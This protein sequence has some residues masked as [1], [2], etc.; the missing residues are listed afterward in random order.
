[1]NL[2]LRK[3]KKIFGI[4]ARWAYLCTPFRGENKVWIDLTDC[5]HNKKS[6]KQ[7]LFIK[8]ANPTHLQSLCGYP[9][10]DVGHRQKRVQSR[11]KH[12]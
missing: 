11:F 5:N 1:M 3:I 7:H 6:L 9:F 2:I 12:N 8:A 4:Y 10:C